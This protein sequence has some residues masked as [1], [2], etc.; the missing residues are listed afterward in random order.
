MAKFTKTQQIIRNAPP[1]QRAQLGRVTGFRRFSNYMVGLDKYG[2]PLEGGAKFGSKVASTLNPLMFAST[3]TARNTAR[4][5]AVGAKNIKQA[6]KA[7][8]QAMKNKAEIVLTI[9]SLGGFAGAKAGVKAGAEAAKAAKGLAKVT[10]G[11][12]GFKAGKEAYKASKLASKAA[13]AGTTAT[14]TAGNLG[15]LAANPYLGK[16]LDLPKSETQTLIEW[17]SQAGKS[18]L[19]TK[20]K[21]PEVKTYNVL[22]E[23]LTTPLKPP[24]F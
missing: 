3:I 14:K 10:E 8:L 23:A 6:N 24:C 19:A 7:Q 15:D 9:A 18:E 13:K 22:D 12:K 2:R 20:F 11:A 16:T 1:E 5:T 4:G 21:V 17:G